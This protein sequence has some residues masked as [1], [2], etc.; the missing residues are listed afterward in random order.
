MG[1]DIYLLEPL[2][3]QGNKQMAEIKRSLCTDCPKIRI[4]SYL[5]GRADVGATI[6]HSVALALG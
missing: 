5:Q 3:W 6:T 4:S 2:M 1:N